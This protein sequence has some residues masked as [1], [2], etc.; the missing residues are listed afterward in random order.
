MAQSFPRKPG[1]GSPCPLHALGFSSLCVKWVKTFLNRGAREPCGGPSRCP[2]QT[3]AG[4]PA[5]DPAAG[6]IIIQDFRPVASEGHV[7]RGRGQSLPGRQHSLLA[8]P[9]TAG[10]VSAWPGGLERQVG[11]GLA[12]QPREPGAAP[13]VPLEPRLGARAFVLLPQPLSLGQ[14]WTPFSPPLI[15]CMLGALCARPWAR[16]RPQEWTGPQVRARPAG[17]CPQGAA[18]PARPTLPLYPRTQKWFS[19]RG[20]L[21]GRTGAGHLL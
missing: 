12:A 21:P 13:T 18:L 10:E 7:S 15:S 20:T 4:L 6:R 5:I 8:A 14:W 17:R 9:S 2:A 19:V 16:H 3:P 11:L 1:G